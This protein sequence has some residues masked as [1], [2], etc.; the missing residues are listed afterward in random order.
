VF[1]RRI[2][3]D[4]QRRAECVTQ[5]IAEIEALKRLKHHYVVEFVGSYTNLKYIGLIM[6]PVADIDLS[7]Y[8]AGTN[9]ARY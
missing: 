3:E 2:E 8:L 5:F 6:S 4:I 7:T 1:S 9:T